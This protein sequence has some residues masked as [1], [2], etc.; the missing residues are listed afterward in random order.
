MLKGKVSNSTQDGLWEGEGSKDEWAEELVSAAPTSYT[1]TERRRG[2]ITIDRSSDKLFN[3]STLKHL[4][5][6]AEHNYALRFQF[7]WCKV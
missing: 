3:L 7:I 6:N 4:V 5:P 2:G 1:Y